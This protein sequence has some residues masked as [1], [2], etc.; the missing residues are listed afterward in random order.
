MKPTEGGHRLLDRVCLTL[1]HRRRAVAAVLLA[2]HLALGALYGIA[3]P[4]WEAHDEWAHYK[5]VEYVA[6]HRALPPPGERLTNEYEFD[7]ASQP[8]LYYILAALPVMLVDT[9]D[10]LTPQVNPY[11][12][13]DTGVGGINAA[14]HHPDQERFPPRGTL[15][16]LYLA[17]GM[18]LLISLLGLVATYKL[19]RLLA[20]GRPLVALIALAI[21][22]L[23]PQ[24]LFIS[25]VVTNDVLIAALGCAVTWLSVKTALEGVQTWPALALSAATGLA[26]VT[27]LSALALLPF[28]ALAFLIGTIRALRRGASRRAT[29]ATI[30]IAAAGGA[31]LAGLW[32]WRNFRLT[33]VVLPRD[34]WVLLRLS[35]RWIERSDVAAPIG[36]ATVPGALSYA[37][38]TFWASFGWGNLDAYPWVYWLFAGLCLIGLLGLIAWWIGRGAR[39]EHKQLAGLLALLIGSVVF[40]AAYRDFDYGSTLIRGRYLL[41]ALGA[42][43]VL[44]A[45]GWDALLSRLARWGDSAAAVF[46]TV[47]GLVLVLIN[48]LLPW[49]VIAPAYAPP[50]RVATGTQLGQAVEL[51]P[52]EQPLNARFLAA[53]GDP[54]SGDP[55]AE[56]IAYELWPEVVRPGEA[57]GVTL[58]WR[59]LRPLEHNYTLAV[60]LLDAGLTKVGEVNV[61]P[62]RGNYAT[63]LW[64]PGDVYREIYWV[65]VQR[66]LQQPALGRVK[67]ALFVDGTA[68]ADPGMVGVHLPVTNAQGQPLG[69]AILFGRFKLATTKPPAE[70]GPGPG[71]ATLGDSIRLSGA[72]VQTGP[73]PLVAGEAFTVTLTWDALGQPAADYQVFV[74]LEGAGGAVAYGDGPP[75]GGRYPTDLWARGERVEDVHGVRVPAETPAGAYRLLAGLYDAAGNRVAASGP[76]GARLAADA[77]PLGEVTV[78]RRDRRNFVPWVIAS[79]APESED[80]E[81]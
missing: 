20:P 68:Q 44:V 47:L 19:G 32:V 58:V 26:L 7:E 24:Y 36:W 5:F 12:N 62:G 40:M 21:A 27:K 11:F 66:Q 15:L 6:R 52:G 64:R 63:T 73:A 37:F 39:R 42:V 60:H 50:L 17:R 23:S 65:P 48:V 31:A 13:A 55:A 69:D 76:S 54:A 61:Y 38:R 22:A 70:P 57:L 72:V 4:P 80:K 8:P 9:A 71:L 25:A 77:I 81:P 29:W 67:V 35:Q 3:V 59:V 49:R 1:T 41:P 74:H 43:A 45:T 30:G 28:V 34:P 10:G 2:L 56:L 16:G 46:L 53:S 14:I 75:A 51:L 79:A 33:G 78:L 18:S